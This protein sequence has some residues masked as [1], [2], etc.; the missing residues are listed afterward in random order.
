S[1]KGRVFRNAE[2]TSDVLL[3]SACLP[4]MFQAVEIDGESYWDGG[5][6]GN[7]SMVPLVREC[8]SQDTILVQ[9]N[10]IERPETPRSARD[11]LNRLNEVAFNAVLLKE[12]RMMALLRQ[13]S[14]PGSPELAMLAK[15]RVHR[16]SSTMMTDLGS[17]S[18]LN[19]EWAFLTL[20]RDEGRR[21]A[22]A[23]LASNGADIGVRSSFDLEPLLKG[24]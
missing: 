5:Y 17:S 14:E 2:I 19:A 16:I 11:I 9:I 7:P 22:D 8:T 13:L 3:A 12:L 20:L 4:T 24:L 21:A 1:G 23:F 15:M 10:P 18:K 6:S